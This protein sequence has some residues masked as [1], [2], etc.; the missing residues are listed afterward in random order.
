MAKKD[1]H[2]AL[3]EASDRNPVL[4][5]AKRSWY[6]LWY[7]DSLLSWIV[8]FVLAFVVIKFLVYPGL[9]AIMGTSHPIVAVVSGS[10]EHH[11]SFEQWWTS[12]AYCGPPGCSISCQCTQQEWYIDKDINIDTFQTFPFRNGF[13]KGD[14]IVLFGVKPDQVKLGDVIVFQA[15]KPY[16]IIHRVVRLP[17]QTQPFFQTKGDNNMNM[18][19]EFDQGSAILNEEAVGKDSVIGRAAFRIRFVG[20]IKIWATDYVLRPLFGIS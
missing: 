10:M 1:R 15:R 7:E 8:N 6:F 18:I 5:Y 9:G 17:T 12:P 4:R 2:S 16:P 13:D 20:Y 3:K 19:S 11:G 14:I